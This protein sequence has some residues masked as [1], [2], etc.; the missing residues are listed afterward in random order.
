MYIYP[1]SLFFVTYYCSFLAKLFFDALATLL[2]LSLILN[3]FKMKQTTQIKG[4]K[5]RNTDCVCQLIVMWLCRS[6]E[7]AG[8]SAGS[9]VSRVTGYPKLL[10][11]ILRGTW[12]PGS[13]FFC[14]LFDFVNSSNRC[15]D[16]SLGNLKFW[17]D[18]RKTEDHQSHYLSSSG[19]YEYLYQI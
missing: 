12:M 9:L 14:Y 15:W 6:E 13:F 10:Q 19:D 5:E 7:L 8:W 2:S 17:P 16:I 4:S 18:R 11:F 3:W 1:G